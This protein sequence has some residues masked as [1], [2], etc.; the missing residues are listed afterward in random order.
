MVFISLRKVKVTGHEDVLCR[1]WQGNTDL[2]KRC[3][4]EL[5]Y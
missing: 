5:L 2:Q 4:H 1:M 3:V